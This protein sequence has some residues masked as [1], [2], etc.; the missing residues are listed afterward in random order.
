[1]HGKVLHQGNKGN[2][3]EFLKASGMARVKA[4]PAAVQKMPRSWSLL[5]PGQLVTTQSI[6]VLNKLQTIT[7]N[8]LRYIH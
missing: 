3:E 5:L 8:W 7:S 6:P 1:M 2:E 4:E